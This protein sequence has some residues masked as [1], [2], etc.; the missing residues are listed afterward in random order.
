MKAINIFFITQ[1]YDENDPYRSNVVEW[2]RQIS[3][4]PKVD[5]IHILTRYKSNSIPSNN[6]SISNIQSKFKIIRFLKFY[7]EILKQIP[8]NSIIFIHMGGPYAINLFLFKIL[9]R[10]KVYQWWA[11][12]VL[13]ISNRLGFYLTINKLFTCTESSFPINSP[14]KNIIGHGVDLNKFPLYLSKNLNLTIN[15]NKKS[16]VT[17]SRLTFRKNIHKMINLID[18]MNGRSRDNIQ[19]IIYGSPLNKNDI[20]YQNYLNELI[21]RSNLCEFVKIFPAV[22]H[23][24]LHSYYKSHNVYLNFSDTALDKSLLEAMSTGIP[25]LSCNKCLAET[26]EDKKFLKLM[27]FDKKDNLSVLS[28]KVKRFINLSEEELEEYKIKSHNIIKSKHSIEKLTNTI[29]NN[30]YDDIYENSK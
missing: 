16:L 13:S 17:S 23:S 21:N 28:D 30:I 15:S 20:L 29:V 5:H 10:L 12:P 7:F 27:Y 4:N 25:V 8:K 18:F 24:K 9:F 26:I 6:C 3:I 1:I 22:D 14:K 19:L 2:I 11:H